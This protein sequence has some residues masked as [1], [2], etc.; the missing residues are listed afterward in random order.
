MSNFFNKSLLKLDAYVPGEQLNDKKYIKLNTNESPYPPSPDVYSAIAGSDISKLRLYPDPECKALKQAIADEYSVDYDNV[1]VSNGSDE[2]LNFFFM[3]FCDNGVAFP[4]IT[5]GFYKVFS[6]L[7]L[8]DYQMI[9]LNN[10]FTVNVDDYIGINKNI[11]I[12]NPNAPTGMTLSLCEIEKILTSNSRNLV[13]IDEAYVDFGAES[14]VQLINKHKNLLVVH[15][16]SKSRSLAGA[17]LGFA[18]ADKEI[19]A[20]LEKIRYSTN[21]YNINQ[22]TLKIGKA[23]IKSSNYYHENCI[24]I[25]D[26]RNYVVSEL[27]KL[28]FEVIDSKANF[29]FAKNSSLSGETLYK[30]LREKGVLVR[31]FSS[32]LISEYNRITIGSKEDMEIFVEKVKECLNEKQ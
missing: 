32:E 10:N 31:H 15:T 13:V 25:Q 14:A 27:K 18:F 17:R 30:M 9:P 7:Y 3:A 12:A 6:E 11:V 26:T 23:A 8:L 4:N 28:N 21:P 5:Y 1:F 24:K 19:I 20:D 16:F 29:I 22:M 2:V